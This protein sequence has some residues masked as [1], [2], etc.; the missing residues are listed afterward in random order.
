[1]LTYTGDRSISFRNT[2][3]SN[4]HLEAFIA[5]ERGAYDS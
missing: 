2:T 4:V 1:M 3:Q 5:Q